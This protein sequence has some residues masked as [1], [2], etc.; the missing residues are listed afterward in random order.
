MR[1]WTPGQKPVVIRD[2]KTIVEGRYQWHIVPP[3]ILFTLDRLR[4]ERHELTGELSV[5]VDRDGEFAGART[6]PSGSLV[7]AD[8][9][10]SS[11]RARK[12]RATMLADRAKTEN[13]VDWVG[14]LEEFCERVFDAERSGSPDRDLSEYPRPEPDDYV[15]ID[16]VTLLKNHPVIAFG[17]GGSFKSYLALYLAGRMALNGAKVLY[18][19]WELS[20]SEHRDR[21]DKLFGHE[22]RPAMRY[23][24][25]ERPLV[26]EADRLRRI[27]TERPIDYVI[28]D[29][30][31]Y[32][33]QGAPEAAETA[34]DYFRALRQLGIGSLL[35]AHVSK[36]LEGNDQKPF[37]SV[38]WHNSAR[39]TYYIQRQDSDGPDINV[40]VF[41]RK[42]NLGPRMR[43]VGFSI[44]FGP[45]RTWVH[46]TDVRDVPELA[47]KLS[48]TQRIAHAVRRGPQP[49]S[50][51]AETLDKKEDTIRRVVDRYPERFLRRR[52]MDGT[53][54][55]S[56]VANDGPE[57]T[58]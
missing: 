54:V 49:L 31:A 26:H 29:S 38:F 51:L 28:C 44:R 30:V 37:G 41:P 43:P 47:E 57:R 22:A 5:Q 9:N 34:G 15:T 12:D 14:Y 3:G 24:R 25:C 6:T 40:G 27:V 56:L 52:N 45:E 32:G 55:V 53:Q 23:V 18:A 4:R 10:L 1:D 19:D 50:K 58:E 17:D 42:A 16:G 39:A 7:T 48:L 46:S 11:A 2:F 20:G 8:F 13:R 21:F 35:I 36:M 33:C